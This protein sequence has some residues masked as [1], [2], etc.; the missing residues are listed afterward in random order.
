MNTNEIGK[1]SVE[2]L[3]DK[4][5]D[6]DR[7]A[8]DAA[9]YILRN[10]HDAEDAV[11]NAKIK[12]WNAI[13][14]GMVEWMGKSEF[15]A[16]YMKIVRNEA[17]NIGR[18]K[19]IIR[20]NEEQST[21]PD[22][23]ISPVPS[24]EVQAD[25]KIFSE[26]FFSYMSEENVLRKEMDKIR[27]VIENPYSIT[28]PSDP[29]YWSWFYIHFGLHRAHLVSRFPEWIDD[30]RKNQTDMLEIIASACSQV[31]FPDWGADEK[32]WELK[33]KENDE[34]ELPPLLQFW[35]EIHP[36]VGTPIFSHA[37]I[38][39]FF[40][41]KYNDIDIRTWQRWMAIVRYKLYGKETGLHD[42]IKNLEKIEN[43]NTA[44]IP[45]VMMIVRI[46]LGDCHEKNQ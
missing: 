22:D 18:K 21:Y 17:I 11:Q 19:K 33:N 35:N 6:Y 9:F 46:I 45:L 39:H 3:I 26:C 8:H 23:C 36:K 29:V 24:P 43:K 28:R 4:L 12:A 32:K 34:C 20:Q 37:D 5:N 30:T 31:K 1:P 13:S 15:R 25:R 2:E 10:D 42:R 40:S 27:K 16:W 44:G 38:H 7:D 41:E 14:E